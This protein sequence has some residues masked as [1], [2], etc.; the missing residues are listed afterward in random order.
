MT[1]FTFPAGFPAILHIRYPAEYLW[2]DITYPAKY[3]KH[4]TADSNDSNYLHFWLFLYLSVSLFPYMP[5]TLLLWTAS[6]WFI[7]HLFFL[8]FGVF[9]FNLGNLKALCGSRWN[10]YKKMIVAEK[11]FL[12]GYSAQQFWLFW[13]IFMNL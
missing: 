7:I 10:E 9:V 2:I 13:K 6:P 4:A 11:I 12:D 5:N 1:G 8:L 3:S